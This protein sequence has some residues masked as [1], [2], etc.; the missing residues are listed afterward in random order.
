MHYAVAG[1]FVVQTRQ[2]KK[3]KKKK[4][5]KKQKKKNTKYDHHGSQMLHAKFG[6]NPFSNSGEEN[7]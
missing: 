3:K 6:S 2:K 4:Q 5:K 7:F 1:A